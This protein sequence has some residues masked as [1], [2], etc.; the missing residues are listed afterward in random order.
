VLILAAGGTF[1]APGPTSD[2]VGVYGVVDR[3]VLAPDSI[4]PETIQLWG[5]FSVAHVYDLNEKGDLESCCDFN[6]YRPAERGYLFY[7]IKDFNPAARSTALA[8]WADLVRVA[9]SGYPVSFGARFPQ[10]IPRLARLGAVK[11]P[12]PV[13][14][15]RAT[16][17]PAT[18]D[19]YP[20]GTGV[21]RL[22][23]SGSNI[24]RDILGVPAPI[25]PADGGQAPAGRVTLVGR[26]IRDSTVQYRFE[27]ETR[28]RKVTSSPVAA[29]R[30]QTSWSPRLELQEGEEY[31]WR[32]WAVSG[33]WKGQPAVSIFR[34]GK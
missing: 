9:G 2:W 32:V 29:G 26:N 19:P 34:A 11:P 6:A 33:E 7:S 5:V 4:K 28:G 22:S 14:V 13:R 21:V 15:R 23:G 3:V 12:P 31:T 18:P 10:N 8:E 25:S 17:A 24:V 16:A 1:A 27:I 20:I 30:G